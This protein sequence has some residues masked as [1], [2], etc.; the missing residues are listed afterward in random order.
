MFLKIV[1]D[2][3]IKMFLSIIEFTLFMGC[4]HFEIQCQMAFVSI[5]QKIFDCLFLIFDTVHG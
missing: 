2:D 4:I 1:L 5:T 3:V